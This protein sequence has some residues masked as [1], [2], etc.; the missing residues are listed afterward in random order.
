[1]AALVAS[2][3]LSTGARVPGVAV[4][5]TTGPPNRSAISCVISAVK[6]PFCTKKGTSAFRMK[7]PEPPKQ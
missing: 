4:D 7:I 3:A 1:M 2:A 5:F 6:R